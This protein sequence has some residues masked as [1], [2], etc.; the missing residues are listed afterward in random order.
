MIKPIIYPLRE[1]IGLKRT[2]GQIMAEK[3]NIYETISA[4]MSEVGAI[5]KNSKNEQ[6]KFMFRG[7]DA[8]MNALAPALQKNKLFIVPEVLDQTREERTSSKGNAIIYSICRVKY[9]FYAEDGSSISAT[10]IGE[11]MDSGDKATNKAMSI[12]FKYACF[13]VFCIPTEE[14]VDP[15]AEC[16]EVKVRKKTNIKTEEEMKATETQTIDALAL[17][18]V[19]ARLAETSKQLGKTL[20]EE[21]LCKMVG[22][23]SLDKMTYPQLRVLNE[24]IDRWMGA[25]K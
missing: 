23:E 20:D 22:C 4:V 10:V 14:M 18:A 11:G 25:K 17:T 6:Q 12:A 24:N 13:Q 3:K 9:T 16:H 5:G 8:V 2:G 15:D 1:K 21:A 7:I 19:K